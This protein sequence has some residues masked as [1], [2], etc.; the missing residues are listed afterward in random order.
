MMMFYPLHL[1][2]LFC[3]MWRYAP[4]RSTPLIDA[5]QDVN[6]TM[7]EE[8]GGRITMYF[9][10]ARD[11]GDSGNDLTLDETTHLLWA[12]GPVIDINQQTI[13]F[14]STNRGASSEITFPSAE[15]CPDAAIGKNVGV[16]YHGRAGSDC[17][18]SMSKWFVFGMLK[19]TSPLVSKLTFNSLFYELR[20]TQE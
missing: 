13:S 11:T 16:C 4:S 20:L 1:S 9:T 19:S 2:E 3:T 5:S 6:M 12:T 18:L 14:H 17:T 15:E 8:V 10:R 7:V